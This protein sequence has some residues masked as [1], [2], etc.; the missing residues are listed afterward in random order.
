MTEHPSPAVSRRTFLGACAAGVGATMIGCHGCAVGSRAPAQT[1]TA[2]NGAAVA[3]LSPGL[4]LV[5]YHVH[6]DNSTIAAV[7]ALGRERGVKFGIVEHAGTPE[8][9]YPIVLSTDAQLNA[10]LAMLDGH[11]VYRGVQAEWTDWTS[12]FSRAALARLDYVLMDAMTFP[13]RDGRRVKLWEKDAPERVGLTDPRAFM[14]RFVAW[15]VDLIETQPID[16]FGNF[17]WL[18]APLAPDYDALWTPER[19]KRVAA[20]A[21]RHGVA[22]EISSSYQLPRLPFLRVCREAGLK[23]SFGSNGRYPNMGKLDYSLAMAGQLGLT[24]S[25]LFVPAPAGRKAV[26]RWKKPQ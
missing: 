17:S 20:A 13:G 8:N 22:I 3:P 12:G 2:A 4:P 19:M 26:D 23:F 9:A 11:G 15:H 5:D 14:D 6:L 18:P 7:A 21:A 24:A 25:D 10:Y 16:I 1:S